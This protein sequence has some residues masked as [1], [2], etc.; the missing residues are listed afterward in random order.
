LLLDRRSEYFNGRQI[1]GALN[2]KSAESEWHQGGEGKLLFQELH[3]SR[4]AKCVDRASA[5]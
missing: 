5:S 3:Q 2:R 4:L 1:V